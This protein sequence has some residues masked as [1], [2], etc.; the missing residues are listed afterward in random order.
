MDWFTCVLFES[1]PILGGLLFTLN[2]MLLV[3]WR[4]SGRGR[5]LLA[6]L[7]LTVLLLAIQALVVTHR[8]HARRILA[9]IE[10]DITAARTENLAAALAPNFDADGF[11]PEEFLELI[12]RQYERVTVHAVKGSQF[13]V[14]R[15]DAQHFVLTVAYRGEVTVNEYSGQIRTRWEITFVR[16]DSGWR[17]D[18]IQ[19]RHIDGLANPSWRMIARH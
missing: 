11:G 18:G 8:E 4:R 12:T 2:F 1:L 7:A 15:S 19:P 17:I 9:G 14:E 5:P 16:T 3:Y 6:G 13:H 10:R